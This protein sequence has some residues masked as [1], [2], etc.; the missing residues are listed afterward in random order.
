MVFQNYAIFPHMSVSENVAFGL[1]N[2]KIKEPELSKKINEILSVVKIAHL[3]DRMPNEMSGGQQQRLALARAIV[4]QPDV[5]LMDEPLSNLDAKLRVEMRE[6]IKEIQQEYK[7]T[8]VY[9]THDQE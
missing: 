5:L 8:T 3:K 6:A 4:V 1:K 9:V 7:I 2:K